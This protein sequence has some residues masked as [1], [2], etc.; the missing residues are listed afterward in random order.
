M[1]QDYFSPQSLAFALYLGVIAIVLRRGERPA[2]G[3]RSRQALWTVLLIPLI[4]AIVISHQLTPVMLVASR[5]P[6]C[7]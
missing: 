6:R 5:W 2:R 4:T 7:A 1:G 3:R